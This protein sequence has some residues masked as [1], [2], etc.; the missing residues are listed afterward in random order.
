MY[1]QCSCLYMYQYS[2]YIFNIGAYS[3]TYT[4]IG[5]TLIL[6]N[7]NCFAMTMYQ[8]LLMIPFLCTQ[9]LGPKE[10]HVR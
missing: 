4:S 2:D 3:D 6:M 9:K 7:N 5:A 1:R 10:V 8:S